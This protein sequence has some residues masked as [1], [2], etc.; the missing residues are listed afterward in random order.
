M[1][2]EVS[3]DVFYLLNLFKQIN[4]Y[5][6]DQLKISYDDLI[7][8]GTNDLTKEQTKNR[9][10]IQTNNSNSLLQTLVGLFSP[11]NSLFK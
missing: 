7:I 9:P 1:T 6:N 2:E 3:S 8:D 10:N 5:E 4:E 11:L